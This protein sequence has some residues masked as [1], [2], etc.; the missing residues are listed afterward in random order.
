[1][2]YPYYNKYVTGKKII[3][4]FKKLQKFRPVNPLFI[5]INYTGLLPLI[6][7]TDYFS[8]ECRVKCHF[9]KNLSPYEYY[10][11]HREEY[12]EL[13]YLELDSKLNQ[14]IRGCN[15]FPLP[16]TISVYKYFKPE[17][18]LDFSAGWGDRLI[19]AIAYGCEYTGIDPS[20]CMQPK[21]KEII[22][23]FRKDPKEYK[24]VKKPFEDYNVKKDYYD[25][26]FTSPPF[27]DLEIYENLSTQSVVKFNTLDKWK[28]NFLYPS[29]KKS[30]L[31]LKKGGHLAIYI[32]DYRKVRYIKD[33]K[34]Y[35]K[36]FEYLKSV[37]NI[38]W[39]NK[40]GSKYP[41]IIYVWG[42]T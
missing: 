38:K 32:S 42:K 35:L 14:D 8:E 6:K 24:V 11:L 29:L 3:S 18:V 20:K 36:R 4:D 31:S 33:M 17:K 28:N 39:I 13:N 19:G 27:F 10:N 41:R 15:N 5:E 2:D 22:D 21:Y 25:L 30:Y 26:V 40:D 9:N 12:E 23:F 16:V 7:I 37:E 1:M 34:D